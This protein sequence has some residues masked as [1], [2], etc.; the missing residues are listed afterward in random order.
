[1]YFFVLSFFVCAGAPG[2]VCPRSVWLLHST[3]LGACEAIV[4]VIGLWRNVVVGVCGIREAGSALLVPV[5]WSRVLL[6]FVVAGR[7]HT[8][9][10]T[11]V[12]SPGR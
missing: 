4:C 2:S 6:A 10:R 11:R 5:L 8:S 3:A 9:A 7:S 12:V 1:M